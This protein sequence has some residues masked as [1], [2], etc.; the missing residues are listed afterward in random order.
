MFVKSFGSPS[1]SGM[2]LALLT[3]CSAEQRITNEG[4]MIKSIHVVTYP[5]EFLGPAN[6]QEIIDRGHRLAVELSK[7]Y[8]RALVHVAVSKR[9]SGPNEYSIE[10][11][12]DEH[13]DALAVVKSITDSMLYTSDV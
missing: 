3:A 2:A 11:D 10:C 7:E 5:G 8:P 4:T 12:E 13:D 9:G 1:G 6:E